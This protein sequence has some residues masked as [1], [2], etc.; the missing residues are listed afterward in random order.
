[1]S[2]RVTTE[3]ANQIADH[4]RFQSVDPYFARDIRTLAAERDELREEVDWWRANGCSNED[5][6]RIRLGQKQAV[7]R[8]IH[9]EAERDDLLAAA[10]AVVERWDTPSWKDA[11]PTG[12]VIGQLRRAIAASINAEAEGEEED[13]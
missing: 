7:E 2:D 11:V 8:A 4:L 13:A 12:E 5:V 10:K 3:R 6:D 1:M 9:A